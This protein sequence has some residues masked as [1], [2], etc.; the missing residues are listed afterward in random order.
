ML[1]S[2]MLIRARTGQWPLQRD[3][4]RIE[5]SDLRRWADQHFETHGRSW[6]RHYLTYEFRR[7]KD[8]QEERKSISDAGLD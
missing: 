3:H 4:I 2:N 1:A 8:F 5:E 6:I 7:R